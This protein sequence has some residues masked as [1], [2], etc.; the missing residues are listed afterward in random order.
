MPFALIGGMALAV[1][2]Q[3][4]STSDVDFIVAMD[5]TVL[6]EALVKDG[7]AFFVFEPEQLPF[8]HMYILRSHIKVE[9]RLVTIDMIAVDGDW[10]ESIMQRAR[11]IQ[12]NGL[13]I[14]VASAEDII[15]LKLFSERAKDA[16]DIRGLILQRGSML[17]RGYVEQWSGTLGTSARWQSYKVHP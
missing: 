2:G 8:P 3:P 9:Q 17:D 16:E 10:A 11:Y 6:Q 13:S 7:R 12:L 1:Y 15:L 5:R 4:R 14:R